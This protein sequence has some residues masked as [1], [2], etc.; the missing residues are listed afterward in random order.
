MIADVVWFLSRPVRLES[1]VSDRWPLWRREVLTRAC[2]LV[3][4]DPDEVMRSILAQR[5][6]CDDDLEEA[7]L[8]MQGLVEWAVKKYGFIR[9]SAE[10]LEMIESCKTAIFVTSTEMVEI[11]PE[12]MGKKLGA[13]QIKHIITEHVEAGRLK[14]LRFCERNQANGYELDAKAVQAYLD[15][16]QHRKEVAGNDAA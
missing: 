16:Y 14:A 7:T 15:A 8:F 3:R 1:S 6:D 12:I 13:K 4:T 10:G 9:K 11:W 5:E 2:E